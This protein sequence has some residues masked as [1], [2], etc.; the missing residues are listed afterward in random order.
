MYHH[1]NKYIE[2]IY[3]STNIQH[4]TLELNYKQCIGLFSCHYK[5][6]Y[7]WWIVEQFQILK[8]TIYNSGFLSPACD[9]DSI[10]RLW[11]MHKSFNPFF[12]TAEKRNNFQFVFCIICGL[13]EYRSEFINAAKKFMFNLRCIITA[14][15]SV[16]IFQ[17]LV[18]TRKII[19]LVWFTDSVKVFA[20]LARTSCLTLCYAG[21]KSH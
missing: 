2:S 16:L 4:T 1:S 6:V 18:I 15:N 17:N 14:K 12:C 21:S 11:Y 10:W 5:Y 8:F 20:F 9:L 3:I 19:L 7:K 13:F